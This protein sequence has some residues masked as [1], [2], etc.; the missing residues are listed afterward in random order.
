MI[1][2]LENGADSA[3]SFPQLNKEY[4]KQI[5]LFRDG[6]GEGQLKFVVDHE[7]SQLLKAFQLIDARYQPKFTMV[8]VNKRINTRLFMRMV[9]RLRNQL[10]Y[11]NV[12]REYLID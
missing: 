1:V 4:P 6:V 7:V 9:G 8:I 5:V 12:E 3:Y 10:T 2:C 11:S